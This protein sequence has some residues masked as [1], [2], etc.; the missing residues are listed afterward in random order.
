MKENKNKNLITEK[1]QL[2]HTQNKNKF[3]SY[4]HPHIHSRT[5]KKNSNS[6]NKEKQK[7]DKLYNNIS[8]FKFLFI[9]KPSKVYQ[10]RFNIS[11]HFLIRLISI[12]YGL[13]SLSFLY[14]NNKII[15][16]KFQF[17][18]IINYI[19]IL[20]SIL[21]YISLYKYS[22]IITTISYYIYVFFL[23][24]KIYLY[25]KV[26]NIKLKAHH[27]PINALMGVIIGLS[28]NSIAHFFCTWIIF[29]YMVFTYNYKKYYQI[30]NKI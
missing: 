27:Y 14:E 8:N 2:P 4:Y 20:T 3:K 10:K 24:Y 11:L 18:L 1:K 17:N 16:N 9:Y 5:Y 29:S 19:F 6:Q 21:L 13:S 23:G 28:L 26:L 22:K 7:I 25:G 12:I 30:P 15:S